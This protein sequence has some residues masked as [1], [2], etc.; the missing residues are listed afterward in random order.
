MTKLEL[1][2]YPLWFW[3]IFL[4][5]RLSRA[6]QFWGNP[7]D[8]LGRCGLGYWWIMPLNIPSIGILVRRVPD[9]FTKGLLRFPSTVITDGFQ[10]IVMSLGKH[11]GWH[12]KVNHIQRC[13]VYVN[14]WS[15]AGGTS[16]EG[17]RTFR[18]LSI[19]RR[20]GLLE[21]NTEVL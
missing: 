7:Q 18:S 9:F 11:C 2:P 19:T 1:E 13:S 20:N 10:V 21:A 16:L 8:K 6:G 5:I 4:S 12:V 14:T 3:T 17:C 15:W